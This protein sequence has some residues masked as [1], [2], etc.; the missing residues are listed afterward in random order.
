MASTAVQS[1]NTST[2]SFD[3][4]HAADQNSAYSF[5][6]GGA[7]WIQDSES[8]ITN[9][10]LFSQQFNDIRGTFPAMVSN[11]TAATAG[12]ENGDS[13]L[14]NTFPAMYETI[15]SF[16]DWMLDYSQPVM[17]SSITDNME[18]VNFDVQPEIS[19]GHEYDNTNNETG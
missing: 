8:A 4:Q 9:D 6:P 19:D 18:L 5:Q 10:V 16:E 1:S 14:D 15:P 7:T 17:D 2:V 13:A 3:V 12:F 11:N